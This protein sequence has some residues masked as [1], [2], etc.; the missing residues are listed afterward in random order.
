MAELGGTPA[1]SSF[2]WA[3]GEMVLGANPALWM[4]GAGPMFA[5]VVYRN[6]NERDKKIAQLIVDKGWVTTM[7][8]TEPDAGSD[9]GAGRTKA[10]QNEDGTWNIEGVK[11][12]ITSAESDLSDNVDP[13]GARPP[14]G[15]RG[16]R[17]P[18]HQGPEPV[19]RAEV[20]L[21]RGDR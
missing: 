13:H 5:G 9:V 11:R 20:P 8:L 4:Y 2:N 17:R 12:F 3:L 19:H 10:T 14:R 21:R 16:R 7:V 15:R 6:G 18:G 1:P